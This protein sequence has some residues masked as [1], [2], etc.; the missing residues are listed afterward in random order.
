MKTRED[1]RKKNNK[2]NL[3]LL[4]AAIIIIIAIIVGV[5]IHNRHTAANQK[6]QQFATT[7]FNPNVKIDGVK[8]G[9]LTVAKATAKINKLAKNNVNLKNGKVVY[10]RN[11]NEQ[12]TSQAEVKSFFNKQHTNLPSNQ[13]YVYNSKDLATA[14]KKLKNIDD[15]VVNFKVGG[16]D[17]KLKG[18]NLI[19]NASY[20]NN[21]YQVNDSQAINNEIKKINK[22][23]STIHKSYQFAVP[24]GNKVKGKIITVKNK[25]Y[26][27]GV[28]DK[29]AKIAIENAFLKDKKTVNGSDYL[30]GLGYSTY[31]HGYMLSNH[32]IGKT[33]VVVSLKKQE[34]WQI[35]KGKITNHLTDVV[36]GTME[37]SKGNQTPRGVWYIHYKERGATLR[38]QND[39]GSSYASPVTYWMPFTLSG[40]GFHDA[41]W[42]TDWSKTAYLKGGSHGC[43]NVKPA[44]IRSVWNH[45]HKNE[46]VIIYD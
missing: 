28:Y 16:K 23:V 25:T 27:W 4:L 24:K 7:H 37:G 43:V 39:D 29:R 12:T 17:F 46:P 13:N 18:R 10:S 19:T 44:E 1:V 32:G 9:K 35:E 38:G 22:Q 36:T 31:P 5:V 3:Y 30:Y 40:C 20:K 41:P 8:V 11:P 6:A 21:K 45:M 42:R 34:V 2:N 15:M 26:G 33:Y 14:E